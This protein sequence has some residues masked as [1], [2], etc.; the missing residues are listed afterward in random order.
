MDHAAAT[1]GIELTQIVAL[2]AAAVIAVPIFKRL[3][4]GTV[5]GYLVAGVIIGP[6]GLKLFQET[7][8]VLHTAELGVVLLLFII[9]LEMKPSRLWNLRRQI[10][11]LGLLQV[12]LCGAVLTG[13]SIVAFNLDPVIAFI[14]AMGF[15]MSSTAI[16]VQ[17]LEERNEV[18]APRG[19]RIV[20]ILLFEDLAIVPLLALVAFLAPTASEEQ[21][22][23]VWVQ[24]GTAVIAVAGL[25]FAGRYV[26]TPLFRLLAAT[27]AREIMTA[28]ALLVVLGAA[29]ALEAGGLSMAMGA[30]LAGVILSESNF[31][32]QLEAD[33]EPFRGL[34]LGLFFLAVGMSLDLGVV[35]TDWPRILFIVAVLMAVKAAVVYGLGRILKSSHA[36]ALHRA[37]LM[38]Q[39]GEFAFVLYTVAGGNGLFPADDLAILMAAVILSMA[40]TPLAPISFRWLLP[41]PAP[42][43]EGVEVAENLSGTALII[44][45]GRFGQIVSQFLLARDIDV[46]IIDDD[47][48]MIRNAASFGFKIYYGDG[49]QLHVLRAAGAP[50]AKIVCVCIDDKEGTNLIV[51]LLGEESP[52][53]K[54][55]VRSYDRSHTLVLRQKPIAFEIRET[56]ESA[57]K[58]GEASLGGLGFTADEAAATAEDVRRR[59]RERLRAQEAGGIW[60]G[61]QYMY[62]TLT[63]TPLTPVKTESKPLSEETAAIAADEPAAPAA[64]G[65]PVEPPPEAEKTPG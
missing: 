53:A 35:A 18:S 28:A 29:M 32:H 4:L 30:F 55:Y 31:R 47:P 14:A 42:S 22:I 26:L 60:A 52:D 41:K 59:D 5:L 56:V 37:L 27:R 62:M 11:G 61:D 40:L 21:G 54:I 13:V 57:M 20:S 49:R 10:F 25:V 45:F 3:G 16:V 58:L 23:S 9:G 48:E 44:G 2:L 50:H 46:T 34:L 7:E 8:S 65:A 64:P 43:M 6:F 38:A 39:G 1:G 19:Q 36:D 15:T 24:V 33:I 12:G 63:P 51:D 17:I